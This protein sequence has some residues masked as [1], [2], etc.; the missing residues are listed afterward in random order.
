[1]IDDIGLD[2]PKIDRAQNTST[3]LAATYN[4]KSIIDLMKK[5]CLLFLGNIKRLKSFTGHDITVLTIKENFSILLS[6]SANVIN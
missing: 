6:S 4:L 2:W 3:E 1:M 5:T